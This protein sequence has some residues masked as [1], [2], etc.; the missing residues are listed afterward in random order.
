METNM[1]AE[2]TKRYGTHVGLNADWCVTVWLVAHSGFG[3]NRAVG[4]YLT[5][6]EDGTVSLVWRDFERDELRTIETC[7]AHKWESLPF[8]V[9]LL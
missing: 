4:L 6:N 5:D 9:P 1:E 3:A 2:I 7:D 8:T